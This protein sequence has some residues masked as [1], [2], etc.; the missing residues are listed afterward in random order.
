[1]IVEISTTNPNKVDEKIKKLNKKIKYPN[2]IKILEYTNHDEKIEVDEGIYKNVKFY[3][4]KIEIPENEIIKQK[5]YEFLA[6]I[7]KSPGEEN[8]I[9]IQDKTEKFD[10]IKSLVDEGYIRCDHCEIDR[11]R[12]KGF[13][14]EKENELFIIGSSCVKEYFGID[15]VSELESLAECYIS[16]NDPMI[17][18]DDDYF[19]A[20]RKNKSDYYYIREL[21]A[22][23]TAIILTEGF[24]SKSKA[25]QELKASTLD[26]VRHVLERRGSLTEQQISIRNKY[27]TLEEFKKFLQYFRNIDPSNDFEHNLKIAVETFDTTKAGLIVYGIFKYLLDKVIEPK[28]EKR[29]NEFIGKVGERGEFVLK[30]KHIKKI[31]SYYGVCFLVNFE[32]KSG[33]EVIWW[34]SKPFDFETN[35]TYKVKGRVK[36]HSIYNNRKQTVLTRCKIEEIT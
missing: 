36:D 3:D 19:D 7:E 9:F 33:N 29:T 21:F 11:Y 34:A 24:I 13:V 14:F 2:K 10:E 26:I 25:I 20:V 22:I 31:D 30:F 1:M 6:I 23:G 18:C 16:L 27:R 35:K 15:I 8:Y 12:K 17:I 5:G 4:F 28:K 32:D